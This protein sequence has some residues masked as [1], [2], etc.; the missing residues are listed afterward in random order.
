MYSLIVLFFTL[1]LYFSH[2]LAPFGIVF[3]EGY[4]FERQKFYLLSLFFIISL[5]EAAIFHYA[6]ILR[7]LK[8][9]GYIFLCL[10]IIPM[11]STIYYWG[12]F[13]VDF[14]TGSFEKHHG[15]IFYLCILWYII[16]VSSSS[17]KDQEKYLNWSI[18]S[19]CIVSIIA[20]WEH[21]GW[22][23]DIYSRSEIQ[24]M[25][26]GR[27]SSTLWN[28]NYLA[29]YLIFF[30]PILIE[31]IQW[32]FQKYG[33]IFHQKIIS[34]IMILV[35]LLWGIYTSWSYIT[36]T[37]LVLLV[38]WYCIWWIFPKYSL[39]K[40]WSIFLL[41]S[42]LLFYGASSLVDNEKIL[43]FESRFILMKELSSVLL[44]YPTSIFL[45]FGPDS[46]LSYFSEERSIII[47]RYF[48][49]SMNIDS[50]HNIFIDILFQYGILPI[51]WITLLFRN[52]ISKNY[53][54]Q[55]LISI[56]MGIVFLMLN[57]FIISHIL[58]LIL[59]SSLL[60]QEKNQ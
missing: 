15:Y 60:V 28:P 50:S 48:P 33:S 9:Y 49:S 10:A 38:I 8:K 7:F 6:D 16:L 43:S 30:I 53:T 46:I 39:L 59:I 55:Y 13:S 12:T 11:I 58:L 19:A 26:P 31:R 32:L 5:I 4:S 36:M 34:Q 24:S 47:E 44:E 41:V 2:V 23:L 25:Y 52:R 17:Q 14:W 21:L 45:W 37:I 56:I 1:P 51:I 57:V 22:Y 18:I 42:I 40:K 35:L 20:I 29:G 3:W 27:S 54:H